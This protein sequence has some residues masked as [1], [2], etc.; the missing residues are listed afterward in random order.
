MPR[1]YSELPRLRNNDP[2]LT[3]DGPGRTV[4]SNMR[5]NTNG[6]PGV[7]QYIVQLKDGR[8]RHYSRGEVHLE[9]SAEAEIMA[10]YI[11]K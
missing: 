4:G 5:K 8:I 3:P 2:V 6:G 1:T 7:R 10:T 9:G 11:T